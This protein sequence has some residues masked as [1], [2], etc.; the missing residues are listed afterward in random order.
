MP[1][2]V[3]LVI[4]PMPNASLSEIL[5]SRKRHIARRANIILG[6]TGEAFWQAESYDHWIRNEEEKE[7]I[8]RYVRMNPVKA[9]LCRTP[10]EWRWGSAWE[11]GRMGGNERE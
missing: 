10:E 8:R 1:N 9:G 5:R 11:G 2:H 4:W 7:R 3:H 6:R